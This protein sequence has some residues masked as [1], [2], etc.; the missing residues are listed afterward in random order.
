M[1]ETPVVFSI[2]SPQEEQGLRARTTRKTVT[3]P[4]RIRFSPTVAP[5][6]ARRLDIAV[7]IPRAVESLRIP[8]T[9]R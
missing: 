2:V 7:D 8:L 3:P 5:S 6:I 9:V 1:E 4:R